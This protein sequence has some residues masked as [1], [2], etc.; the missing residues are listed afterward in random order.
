[1]SQDLEN[2]KDNFHPEATGKETVLHFFEFFKLPPFSQNE[3]LE[4]A[5]RK[6]HKIIHCKLQRVSLRIGG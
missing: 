1:M 2:R 4:L 6:L 5:K 3:R